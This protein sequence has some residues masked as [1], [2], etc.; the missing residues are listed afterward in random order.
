MKNKLNMKKVLILTKKD[1]AGSG[2][3]FA[4]AINTYSK[5]Y[6]AV[7]VSTQEPNFGVQK[8]FVTNK[9]QPFI[10]DA[11]IIHLKGDDPITTFRADFNKK[12]IVQTVGGS[13]F[14]SPMENVPKE[15]ALH[16][17]KIDSYKKVPL[18]GITPELIS[19][20][21]WIP[22][23]YEVTE[24]NNYT[25][26]KKGEKIII[27]HAPTSRE[28]KGTEIII[29]A[30]KNIENIE[31]VIIE[32]KSHK[33][34]LEF[35]AKSHLF[36][37]QIFIPAYGMNAV[38]S[39]SLGLPTISSCLDIPNCPIYRV[40]KPTVEEV[41][42][43]IKKAIKS[44]T[45]ATS[46]KFY[47]YAISQHSLKS[48][49]EKLEKMYDENDFVYSQNRTIVQFTYNGKDNIHGTF[50]VAIHNA[51]KLKKAGYGNFEY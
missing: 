40:E 18:Y 8:G 3:M 10:N 24:K 19:F 42:K 14:R 34:C 39:M 37:D 45:K 25:P 43:A 7:Q 36:I 31:L 1:F 30:C 32:N 20:E 11:D 16:T 48:V 22:H 26:P 33:E 4:K 27:T 21:K 35:K 47:N 50:N 17:Y 9:M 29:E 5:K 49:C 2:Y 6:S 38:E 15:A 51:E 41:E 44:L 13:R 28:K 23:A 46:N 12:K